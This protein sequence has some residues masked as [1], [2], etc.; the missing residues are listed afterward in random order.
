MGRELVTGRE[1]ERVLRAAQCSPVYSPTGESYEVV[2]PGVHS[3]TL[4]ANSRM[5]P[6]VPEV[7]RITD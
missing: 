4:T 1:R 5:E 3:G 6:I 7:W 2:F